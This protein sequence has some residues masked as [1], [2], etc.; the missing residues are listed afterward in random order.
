MP[1]SKEPAAKEKMTYSDLFRQAIPVYRPT[2]ITAVSGALGTKKH[3]FMDLLKSDDVMAIVY[4]IIDISF[5]EE[6][7]DDETGDSGHIIYQR[8]TPRKA[9]PQYLLDAMLGKA[10]KDV[11]TDPA[12]E[13]H[14]QGIKY[15]QEYD[16]LV[17]LDE[18]AF[19][20]VGVRKVALHTKPAVRP[21]LAAAIRYTEK[22]MKLPL[23]HL[24]PVS[25]AS[26]LTIPSRAFRA[27][28]DSTGANMDDVAK[29]FN[30]A[31]AE[32]FET[33]KEQDEDDEDNDE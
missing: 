4:P 33:Y 12:K 13:E 23:R 29:E 24:V 6:E 19:D 20:K 22:E 8:I 30:R 18:H 5:E 10:V 26:V 16:M 9:V 14:T 32:M 2:I 21:L 17:N 28:Q 15:L 3:P 31:K 25:K 11:P 27:V 7:R 1:E